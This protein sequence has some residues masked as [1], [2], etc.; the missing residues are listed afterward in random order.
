LRFLDKPSARARAGLSKNEM[1]VQKI[2]ITFLL[3][4]K[5]RFQTRRAMRR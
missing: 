2:A 4:T 5:L 1:V 3:I